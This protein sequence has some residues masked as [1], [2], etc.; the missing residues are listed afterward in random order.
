MN[1]NSETSVNSGEYS[2]RWMDEFGTTYETSPMPTVA[3]ACEQASL[4]LTTYVLPLP[5]SN[6]VA[7]TSSTGRVVAIAVPV[8]IGETITVVR[9]IDL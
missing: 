5:A 6:R 1:T 4:V 8:E 2:A 7:V 9:A 3:D